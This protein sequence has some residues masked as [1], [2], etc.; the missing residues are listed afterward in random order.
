[1][2][3]I[4]M[5]IA[6]L[7]AGPNYVA[8]SL[9]RKILPATSFDSRFCADS[10]RYPLRN[11]N[12]IRILPQSL[13]KNYMLDPQTEAWTEPPSAH[14]NPLFIISLPSPAAKGFPWHSTTTSIT[15]AARS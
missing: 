2:R 11:Y 3:V 14:L 4:Q 10:G 1:M 8:N 12:R 7:L 6:P 9:F 5:Q 13:K 15:C